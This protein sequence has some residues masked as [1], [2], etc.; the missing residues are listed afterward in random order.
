ME[1]LTGSSK[2]IKIGYFGWRKKELR[3]ET[4]SSEK[5]TQSYIGRLYLGITNFEKSYSKLTIF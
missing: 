2:H 3:L 4:R 1:I 5:A